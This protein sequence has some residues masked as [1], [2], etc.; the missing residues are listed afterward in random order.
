MDMPITIPVT[1]K[2][3]SNA[4]IQEATDGGVLGYTDVRE[5][6]HRVRVIVHVPYG[7]SYDRTIHL[8]TH[9]LT[10]CWEC[11]HHMHLSR[12]LME[13]L[14]EYTSW[15]RLRADGDRAEL[16]VIETNPA[17]TYLRGFQQ[18]RRMV[19]QNGLCATLAELTATGRRTSY[20]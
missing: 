19:T 2:Y 10:H 11:E 6:N 9:E 16:R 7:Q 17:L 13:G 4:Q 1:M 14:A 3:E 8:L 12:T 15:V 18:I 5:Q 20:R